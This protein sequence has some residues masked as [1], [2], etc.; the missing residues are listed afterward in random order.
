VPGQAPASAVVTLTIRGGQPDNGCRSDGI[1][2]SQFGFG[3]GQH[4][5]QPA[6]ATRGGSGRIPCR[7]PAP[8]RLLHRLPRPS[9]SYEVEP[10]RRKRCD[11]GSRVCSRGLV[12]GYLSPTAFPAPRALGGDD[13]RAGPSTAASRSCRSSWRRRAGR[14]ALARARSWRKMGVANSCVSGDYP[15]GFRDETCSTSTASRRS[16]CCGNRGAERRIPADLNKG[17][18]PSH[19]SSVSSRN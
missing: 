13:P 11:S 1:F 14:M 17:C 7:A 9:S 4:D 12:Q 15:R 6:A 5:R 10:S 18:V 3:K 16:C 8:A 2:S 19:P